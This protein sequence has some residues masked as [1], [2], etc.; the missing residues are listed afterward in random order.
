MFPNI[1]YETSQHQAEAKSNSAS[2]KKQ[3][4]SLIPTMNTHAKM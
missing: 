3:A 2:A 4:Y 1:F